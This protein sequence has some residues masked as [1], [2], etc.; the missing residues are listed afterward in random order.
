MC[1]NATRAES[2]PISVDFCMLRRCSRF[3]RVVGFLLIWAT[4]AEAFAGE[5]SPSP[6]AQ[7]S[8]APLARKNEIKL[9]VMVG[10]VDQ[11]LKVLKLDEADAV[12]QEV[13]FFETA[14]GELE[15]HQVILR[16]RQKD[17]KAGDSTVKIRV[18]EGTNGELSVEELAITPEQDWTQEDRPSLS[19]SLDDRKLPTGLVP[20]VAAGE[21]S[22]VELFNK[23]Q[24]KLLAARMKDF[25]WDSL[26]RYGPVETRVWR[27]YRTFDG[28]QE[29]VTIERWHL[30]KDGRSLEILEVSAKT[31]AETEEQALAM[32][33]QF[34][35]A[36]KAAGLGEP[37]GQTK[38]RMV[39]DFFKPGR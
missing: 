20:R 11:A 7:I 2:G 25:Q 6:V 26:K 1:L 12:Q 4:A 33:K 5:S 32:A 39:L 31:K 16:A 22:I 9:F 38:T 17:A 14:D 28:F 23:N 36:A 37:S 18:A 10:D 24:Q 19:R 21:G 30:E 8:A 3:A 29:K 35:G 34:F 13:C 15:A 27:E